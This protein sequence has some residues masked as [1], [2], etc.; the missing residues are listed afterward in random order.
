V[1]LA[2][3]QGIYSPETYEKDAYPGYAESDR[4]LFPVKQRSD[5]FP[6]KTIVAGIVLGKAAK[7]YPLSELEKAASPA[8]EDAIGEKRVKVSFDR[9]AKSVQIEDAAGKPLP[10][11]R[12]FW[13]AWYAFHPESE[14][15][16]APGG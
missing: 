7:A 15:F 9:A 13:F 8:F 14:V 4:I 2:R 1:V 12:A 11:L 5:R 3:D 6:P 10:V 16:V